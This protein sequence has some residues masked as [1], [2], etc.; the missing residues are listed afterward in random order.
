M[1][2][3][4]TTLILHARYRKL[5]ISVEKQLEW[6][7]TKTIL[8]VVDVWNEH[9]CKGANE[10]LA[11]MLARM[12]E[13]IKAA[14]AKGVTIIN[15]PSETMEYYKDYP[16]RQRMHAEPKVIFDKADS[17]GKLFTL[18]KDFTWP[19]AV[20]SDGGCSDTPKCHQHRAWTSQ[21]DAIE[22][23]ADDLISDDGMEIYSYIK[24]H[25]I[26]NVII[27]GVH[28]NMCIMGR[29]FGIRKL[30]A[31]HL[32]VV[33]CRDLTDAMYNPRSWPFVSHER[34]TELVVEH[35]ERHWCPSISSKDITGST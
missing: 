31:W 32:N 13:T 9:W 26:E 15:A 27:L 24:S 25:G 19:I 11:A 35:I 23:F 20:M 8:L 29:S 10:R 12:D 28:T 6:D 5:V 33:L 2:D 16:Q 30:V 17:K 21:N 34:G 7:A 1:T 4:G 14:R 22:I 18:R 3:P